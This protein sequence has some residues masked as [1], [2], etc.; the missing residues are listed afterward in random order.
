MSD[1]QISPSLLSANFLYLSDEIKMLNESEAEYI[2]LDIM[3]GIFVPNITF[4]WP[5]ISQIKK[6]SKIKLDVHLMIVDPQRYIVD[7][8]K[9]GA[10]ILCVHYE[11]CNHLHRTISAIKENGMLAGVAL[12]PHTPVSLL[13]DVLNE[14]DLVLIMSVNPGFGGQKFIENT[15]SKIIKLKKMILEKNLNVKIEVDGGVNTENYRK[16]IDAG[17]KILV[18]GNAIFKSEN[19][20]QTIKQLKNYL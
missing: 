3:D 1:I 16:I 9:A 20:K 15:Y 19:P 13:D 8:A 12:N 7:F 14:L 10:D 18:A 5:I 2:H 17:A 4:G 11:A 6:Q